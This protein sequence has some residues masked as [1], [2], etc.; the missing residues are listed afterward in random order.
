MAK[1]R[2]KKRRQTRA[3]K[4]KSNVARPFTPEAKLK[5]SI[6]A[7]FKELGFTKAQDGTLVLPGTG[8]D[9]VRKLHGSQ[10][11][12]RLSHSAAFVER[13]SARALVHFADGA[14][15][16]PAKIQ[17]KLIRVESGTKNSELFRFAT[18]TWS[19][20]VSVGFGRR[21]RYLV[22]DEAHSF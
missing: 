15:I 11:A 1:I 7:H 9:I 8:K 2:A 14:E 17:L 22:W 4:K 13:E 18:L 12:E 10:C 21:L 16:D 6:R 20:P 19:V 5:R 3:P